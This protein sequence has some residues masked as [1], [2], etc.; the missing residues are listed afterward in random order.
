MLEMPKFFFKK[1]EKT[2]S[3]NK[4]N[5]HYVH[6]SYKISSCNIHMIASNFGVSV[7]K[8]LQKC[9]LNICGS[10]CLGMRHEFIYKKNQVNLKL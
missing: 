2:K 4:P 3:K 1:K 8:Y 6:L 10:F 7:F 5:N 9:T